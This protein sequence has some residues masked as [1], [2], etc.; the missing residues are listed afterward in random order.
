MGEKLSPTQPFP[1]RPKSRL[2]QSRK[3]ELWSDQTQ[4][5]AVANPS[6]YEYKGRE[7]VAFV[8][9]GNTILKDQ[10]GDQIVVYALPKQ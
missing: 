5:P 2:D 9:G 3:L 1:T 7:Y 6:V 10:V 8:A 4:A